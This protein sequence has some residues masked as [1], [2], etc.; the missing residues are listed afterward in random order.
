MANIIIGKVAPVFKGE[1]S[2]ATTF[3][4]LD[5]V[6]YNGSSYA[7]LLDNTK[8]VVPTNSSRWVLVASKGDVGSVD[9][10]LGNKTY[11]DF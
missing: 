8:G 11:N 6:S 3:N 5:I 2:S 7:C 1:Y 9:Y 10:N 4:R